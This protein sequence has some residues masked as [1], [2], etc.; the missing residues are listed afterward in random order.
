MTLHARHGSHGPSELVRLQRENKKMRAALEA[1]KEHVRITY[2]S[3]WN[4]PTACDL[5]TEHINPALGL[6]PWGHS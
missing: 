6:D 3:W 5:M 1:C 4:N 2:G